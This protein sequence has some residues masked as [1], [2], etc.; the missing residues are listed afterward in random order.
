M[1]FPPVPVFRVGIAAFAAAAAATLMPLT[2]AQAQILTENFDSLSN[3]GSFATVGA[4][5]SLG[6]FTVTTNSVDVVAA[7]FLGTISGNPPGNVNYIDL[8]GNA[9]GRIASSLL[10]L[11]PGTVQLQFLLAGSQ[12]G[13]TNTVRVSLSGTTFQEDFTLNSSAAFTLFTRNIT[14]AAGT[15]SAQLVFDHT[16]TTSDALGLLLD[17]VTLSQTATNAAAP[18]PSALALLALPLAGMVIRRRRSQSNA[19]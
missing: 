6:A 13:D 15:N 14:V 11:Q 3:G 5:G 2:D 9:S 10:T 7:T 18:E 16:V 19:A 8:D 1:P 17:N 12:R 4:V